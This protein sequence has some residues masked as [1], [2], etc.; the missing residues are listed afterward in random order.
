MTKGRGE[1][2]EDAGDERK[3]KIKKASDDSTFTYCAFTASCYR[4]FGGTGDVG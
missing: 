1:A 3:E 2:A 4:L